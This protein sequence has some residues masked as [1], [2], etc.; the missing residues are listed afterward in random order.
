[1]K[2]SSLAAALALSVLPSLARAQAALNPVTDAL[3]SVEQRQARNL[4]AAA[5][6]FPADKYS[7]K[8]TAAQ[9]SVADILVHLAE[10][11]DQLCSA[12]GGMAAP[13]R[14]AV[15]AAAGRDALIARLRESFQFCE[16]A[17]TGLTDVRLSDQVP[18][19][20]GRQV[21]RGNAVLATVADWA[22]HYSQLAIYLRLNNLL[23]PT[24]R[25]PAGE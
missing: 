20:G 23:P 25:R 11:N 15:T 2:T 12:L 1:M 17:L 6:A 10:G 5:E 21:T 4:V 8:P 13:Q 18:F 22:D 3:R 19:F 9:M 7:F 24:A 16:T 14:T